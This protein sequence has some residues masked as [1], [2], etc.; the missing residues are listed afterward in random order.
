VKIDELE[1][2]AM[3]A[4]PGPWKY[5]P[6][7]YPTDYPGWGSKEHEEVGI[8]SHVG[9]N[10]STAKFIAASNPQTVLKLIAV[11]RAAK[12]IANNMKHSNAHKKLRDEIAKLE[13]E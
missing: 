12:E 11:V 2:L 13:C 9:D 4:T 6:E 10:L 7:A 8:V 1:K 5:F 3:A